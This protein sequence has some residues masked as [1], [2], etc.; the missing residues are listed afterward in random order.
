MFDV[1]VPK[2]KVMGESKGFGFVRFKTDA[3]KAIN[4]LHGRNVGGKKITVQMAKNINR[5]IGESRMQT[6]GTEYMRSG[7]PGSEAR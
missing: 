2:N 4:L 6:R 3:R 1:F 7:V 5:N